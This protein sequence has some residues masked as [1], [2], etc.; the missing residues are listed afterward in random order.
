MAPKR[1]NQQVVSPNNN[2][3]T[4]R[5]NI[6]ASS[7]TSS[8]SSNNN[9][10]LPNLP[11]SSKSTS[12]S[13]QPL[14]ARKSSSL[15]AAA[16]PPQ[17]V[18]AGIWERY[19]SGTPQRVKL[20]DTFMAF[21]VLVGALQFVYCVLVGNYVSLCISLSLSLSFPWKGGGAGE[22]KK[23]LAERKKGPEIFGCIFAALYKKSTER[24]KRLP[25]SL[26]IALQRLPFRLQR[27]RR[28]ICPHR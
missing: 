23:R 14:A 21:L 6:A 19:V 8:T 25:G 15:S 27:H 10:N 11:T 7:S 1:H 20:L 16:P 18:L 3:P 9:N 5:G 28:P 17:D 13:V 26:D 2:P 12:S 4:S 22:E 24:E